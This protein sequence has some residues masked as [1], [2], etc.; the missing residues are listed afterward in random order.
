M[1]RLSGVNG[2]RESKLLHGIR[3]STEVNRIWMRKQ[4][5]IYCRSNPDQKNRRI[6]TEIESFDLKKKQRGSN[7][8]RNLERGSRREVSK[9]SFQPQSRRK[10]KPSME[11]KYASGFSLYT[12]HSGETCTEVPILLRW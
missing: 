12:P 2:S 3:K 5:R 7:K 1:N 8:D 11:T 10:L 9:R 4:N 6:E